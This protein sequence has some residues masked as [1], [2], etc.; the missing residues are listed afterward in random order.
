MSVIKQVVG[1]PARAES[2]RWDGEFGDFPA[3]W[4]ATDMF[5]TE[6]QVLM[7]RTNR[8]PTPC[9]PG[10]YVIRR[11]TRD[12]YPVDRVTYEERWAEQ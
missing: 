7:V 12:F 2:C 11:T 1:K 4:R 6:G 8:G 9:Y 3:E 5:W 10:E